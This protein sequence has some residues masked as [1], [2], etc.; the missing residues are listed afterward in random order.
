MREIHAQWGA[1][2]INQNPISKSAPPQPLIL[3]MAVTIG[4]SGIARTACAVRPSAGPA[5][6]SRD[7]YNRSF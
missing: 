5:G 7:R 3:T 2:Y 6:G 1:L 4:C